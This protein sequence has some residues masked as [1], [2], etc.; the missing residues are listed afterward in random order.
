MIRHKGL[1]PWDDDIDVA[2]T[3]RSAEKLK[4]MSED[5]TLLSKYNFEYDPTV[6]V[7]TKLKFADKGSQISSLHNWVIFNLF[8]L[9]TGWFPS[10]DIYVSEEIDEAYRYCLPLYVNGTCSYVSSDWWPKEYVFTCVILFFVGVQSLANLYSRDDLFPLQRIEFEDFHVNV[11]H[12]YQKVVE[13]MWGAAA[14][15]EGPSSSLY[16]IHTAYTFMRPLLSGFF[17]IHSDMT[18]F[19]ITD[20]ARERLEREKAG[21]T[22]PKE[23]PSRLGSWRSESH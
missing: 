18:P 7:V 20:E 16:S 11:P 21:H 8:I 19:F 17:I 10:A 13:Q 2:M 22:L 15:H 14:L 3:R 5:G 23:R 4:K 1:I 9:I 12:N 6:T